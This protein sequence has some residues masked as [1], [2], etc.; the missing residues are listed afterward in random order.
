MACGTGTTPVPG[1]THGPG[2]PTAA[3]T[4]PPTATVTQPL[5][6]TATQS[7]AA[8]TTQSSAAQ[9]AASSHT[10]AALDEAAERFA[11]LARE[12]R[13][14]KLFVEAREAI[15]ALHQLARWKHATANTR[16]FE[17]ERLDAAVAAMAS[18]TVTLDDA[19]AELRA[20]HIAEAIAAVDR[21]VTDALE[22][23]LGSLPSD[24]VD[25]LERERD[26]VCAHEARAAACARVPAISAAFDGATK[27]RAELRDTLDD[28]VRR[29]RQAGG[30][31]LDLRTRTALA[32]AVG[33][34][35]AFGAPCGAED[36]CAWAQ[37]CMPATHTCE[38]RCFTGA[39]EPCPDRRACVHIPSLD[40][41]YC[42]DAP[43]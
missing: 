35:P 12:L 13:E 6:A 36:L 8:A 10:A 34:G 17:P 39:M 9:A 18:L 30:A 22:R 3:A 2:E 29:I 20:G 11:G 16:P 31:S 5:D 7:P 23:S 43:P 38:H 37:A 28:A 33:E 26:Q 32:H 41:T 27:L 15:V 1:P 21:A 25:E 19:A 14:P 4:Q 42:R 40:G 24:L